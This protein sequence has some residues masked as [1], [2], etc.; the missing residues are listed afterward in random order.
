[1]DVLG[2]TAV[3]RHYAAY[4]VSGKALI[5]MHVYIYIY[6]VHYI[7]LYFTAVHYI[8]IA[9]ATT[10]TITLRCIALYI[11]I[12]TELPLQL[13]YIYVIIYMCIYF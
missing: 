10:S 5:Q 11:V 6:T 9:I 3:G 7:T 13:I 2:H 4:S 12:W 8:V 1:M